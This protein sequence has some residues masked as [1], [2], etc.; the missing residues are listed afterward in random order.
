MN[1]NGIYARDGSGCHNN[2]RVSLGP[3]FRDLL[4]FVG[5]EFGV[6]IFRVHGG[7]ETKEEVWGGYDMLLSNSFWAI[8]RI[9]VK[10]NLEPF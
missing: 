7:W 2:I 5:S 10:L 6:C 4:I 3:A 1:V 9:R 8:P